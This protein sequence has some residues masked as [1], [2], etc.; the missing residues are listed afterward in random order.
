MCCNLALQN[1]I[2]VENMIQ[3]MKEYSKLECFHGDYAQVAVT[4]RGRYKW[5]LMDR[6]GKEVVPATYDSLEYLGGD[7][8]FVNIG[9][10]EGRKYQYSGKWGIINLKN[11]IK[12][13]FR[14]SDLIAWGG[15]AIVCYRN[16]W[17][18]INYD[19]DI[20][21][22]LKYE[23][24]FL[25]DQDQPEFFVF[26]K[27]GKYGLMDNQDQILIAPVYDEIKC[28]N[29]FDPKGWFTVCKEDKWYYINLKGETVLK[30]SDRQDV[31]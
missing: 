4:I 9:Y 24:I 31:L 13:P 29:T 19:G 10:K 14:Y 16:R 12:V 20:I 2:L 15:Y 11:E 21:I 26:K 23:S 18:V 25:T 8:V 3:S 17:G 1:N 30:I 27:E 5:G 7:R 22:R 28:W 6:M